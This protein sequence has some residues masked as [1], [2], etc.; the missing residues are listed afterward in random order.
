[1]KVTGVKSTLKS[2]L[3]VERPMFSRDSLDN[4]KKR[5]RKLKITSE[6]RKLRET[7]WVVGLGQV[8]H[9][10]PFLVNNLLLVTH[11][12]TCVHCPSAAN[13]FSLLSHCDLPS[14]IATRACDVSFLKSHERRDTSG[15]LN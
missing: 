11:C 4:N 8:K 13:I 2:K 6:E 10:S 7:V 3:N 15:H 5:N 14:S 9:L 12:V 1:M